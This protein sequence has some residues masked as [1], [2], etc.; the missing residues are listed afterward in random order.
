MVMNIFG[1]IN[2][3][4]KKKIEKKEEEREERRGKKIMN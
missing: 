2:V 4:E 1:Y 3:K